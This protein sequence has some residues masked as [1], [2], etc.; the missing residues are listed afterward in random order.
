[1]KHSPLLLLLTAYCLLSTPSSSAAEITI[2]P[3]GGTAQVG[4]PFILQVEGLTVTEAKSATTIGVNPTTANVVG[5]LGMEEGTIFLW[6]LATDAN[7]HFVYVSVN[8]GV[9]P[10]VASLKIPVGQEDDV[11]PPPPPPP[12]SD[13][14]RAVILWESDESSPEIAIVLTKLRDNHPLSKKLLILDKD[15]T[16]EDGR[17]SPTAK[18]IA[19]RT[20]SL[21]VIA[22]LSESGDV[23]FVEPLPGTPKEAEELLKRKG[24]Q[25]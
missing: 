8:R 16:D 9:K 1:M 11:V 20:Q 22:G 23:V 7:E 19:G 5:L 4:M 18:K 12:P 14:S 10:V 24:L 2:A 13:V 21:P 25:W 15:A 6:F 17:P 3:L